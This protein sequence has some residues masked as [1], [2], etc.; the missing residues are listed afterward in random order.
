M[1]SELLILISVT[2]IASGV[3]TATGFGTSTI[4][5]PVLSLFYPLPV[6]LLFVGI[7]HLFGD[8]WKVILFKKA[9]NWRLVLSFGIPGIIASYAGAAISLDVSPVLLKRFLGGF[10]LIYVVFLFA[11]QNWELPKSNKLAAVGGSLSGLFAG[12]FGVGGAIRGAF[13]TA[14]NLPKE[15]YI[16]TSGFIALFIDSTRIFKYVTGGIMLQQSLL[17]AMLGCIPIS[18]LGAW[19]AKKFLTKVPQVSFRLLIAVFLGLVALKFLIWS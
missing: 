4:M 12:V 15:V 18:F 8:L 10:L 11:K 9:V 16:F 19:L 7:I 13:L 2:L 14:F 3:G 17:Y 5:V 1:S 6:T